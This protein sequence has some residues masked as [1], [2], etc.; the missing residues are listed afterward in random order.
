[1][2]ERRKTLIAKSRFQTRWIVQVVL[3][4]FILIN[5]AIILTFLFGGRISTPS[6]KLALGIAVGVVELVGIVLLYRY[7]LRHSNRIAGPV[8]RIGQVSEALE[9]GDLTIEARTRKGDYF[10]SEVEALNRAIGAIRN[11]IAE[12]KRDSESDSDSEAT[13]TR[14]RA[15]LSRFKT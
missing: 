13:L 15:G 6:A 3:G 2:E 14:I 8:F 10:Q 4:A 7:A 1:M 9:K 12:L 11:Q 5:I